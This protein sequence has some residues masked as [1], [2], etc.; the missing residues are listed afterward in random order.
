MAGGESEQ[1]FYEVI[2]ET[3]LKMGWLSRD[4]NAVSCARPGGIYPREREEAPQAGLGWVCL[5][6]ER[7]SVWP[8][9]NE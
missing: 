2:K 3:S 6:K 7:R 5:R 9:A 4:D 1:S 8:Q